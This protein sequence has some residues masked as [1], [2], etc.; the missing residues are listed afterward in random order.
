MIHGRD[1]GGARVVIRKA[2]MKRQSNGLGNAPPLGHF[3]WKG[4]RN[5]CAVG[6][7][8]GIRPVAL[9]FHLEGLTFQPDVRPQAALDEMQNGAYILKGLARRDESWEYA[10]LHLPVRMLNRA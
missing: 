1:I 9:I 4:L 2:T 5:G 6:L 8:G 3:N 7:E 10:L